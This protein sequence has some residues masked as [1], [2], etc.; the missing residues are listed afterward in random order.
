MLGSQRSDLMEL[1]GYAVKGPSSL[2]VH[3]DKYGF[4]IATQG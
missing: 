3:E 4:A 1:P 2:K